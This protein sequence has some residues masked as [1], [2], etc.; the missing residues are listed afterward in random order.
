MLILW[1]REGQRIYLI[2]ADSR[3]I[4]IDVTR[5]DGDEG[6]SVELLI[7][8]PPQAARKVCLCPGWEWPDEQF[9]IRAERVGDAQVVLHISAPPAVQIYREEI[10]PPYLRERRAPPEA[11]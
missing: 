6:K 3:V 8:A 4:T 9:T 1:R 2:D 7:E 5:I 11:A 10:A